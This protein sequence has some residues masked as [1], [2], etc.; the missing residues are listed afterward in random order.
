MDWAPG[1][2]E[3]APPPEL[4][5]SVACLWTRVVRRGGGQVTLSC[6]PSTTTTTEPPTTTFALP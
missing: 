2:R 4:G 1:Y 6:E 5:G 3:W